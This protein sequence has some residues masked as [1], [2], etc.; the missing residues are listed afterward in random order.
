[1]TST[2]DY[3]VLGVALLILAP[4]LL[5]PAGWLF[6]ALVVVLWLVVAYGGRELW[7]MEKTRRQGERGKMHEVRSWRDREGER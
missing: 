5:S 4:V 2:F 3:V 6:A 7:D 1:M